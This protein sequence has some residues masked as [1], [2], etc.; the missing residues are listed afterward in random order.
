MQPPTL[1]D[2][3]FRPGQRIAV[4]D[5]GGADSLAL[6]RRL[7]QR[8]AA[9]GPVLSAAHVH[10]GIRGA[11]ADEDAAFV[12]NLAAAHSLPFHLHR[13]DAPAAAATLHETLEEAARNLRYAFFRELMA[14]SSVDAVA[15]AHTLDDQA[16]TVLHK[17]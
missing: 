5:S 1:R 16:E 15:T 17:L 11:D 4:A 8:R 13:A 3:L 7:H 12:G 9:L 14:G 2:R 10:H 6:P